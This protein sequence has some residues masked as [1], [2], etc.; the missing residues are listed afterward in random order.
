MRCALVT[1]DSAVR[2]PGAAYAAFLIQVADLLDNLREFLPV[3]V[4]SRSDNWA[5]VK[6][7][8]HGE[9]VCQISL[10]WLQVRTNGRA[11]T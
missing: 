3:A 2:S 9:D 6:G 7:F 10:G 11:S 1:H 5:I 4:N 8:S